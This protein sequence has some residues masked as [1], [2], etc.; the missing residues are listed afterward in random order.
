M[1]VGVQGILKRINFVLDQYDHY[2]KNYRSYANI[3]E[4]TNIYTLLTST[5]EAFAP[6]GSRFYYNL[7]HV[8]RNAKDLSSNQLRDAN[9]SLAGI[10]TALKLAYEHD[11]LASVH[12]VIH[13][14]LFDDFLE[15]SEYLLSEGYKDAAVV[16]IGG[17]LEEH[18]RKMCLKHDIEIEKDGG[19]PVKADRMN[20]DLYT[21]NVYNKGNNKSITAWLDL[22]NNAAHAKYDEYTDSQ[23]ELMLMGVRDFINRYPA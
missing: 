21:A 17:V 10:L 18:L 23:V 9:G 14:D 12:E 19:T 13:A 22:R 6:A 8:I 2:Y 4:H 16:M 7:A 15:M 11:L 3:E 20:Q 1:P 5:I